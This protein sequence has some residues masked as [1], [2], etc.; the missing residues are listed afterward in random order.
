MNIDFGYLGKVVLEDIEPVNI[1]EG[2]YK[3]TVVNDGYTELGTRVHGIISLD[4]KYPEIWKNAILV[5]LNV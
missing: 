3:F 5:K 1:D 4:D 2:K